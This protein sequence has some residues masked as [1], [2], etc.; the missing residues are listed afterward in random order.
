MQLNPQHFTLSKLFVGRLFRIPE[1]QRPYAW[2]KPQ[3]IDLF[4]DLLEVERSDQDHFMATLVTLKTGSRRIGPDEFTVVDVVDGQQRLTTLIML[5]KAIE[6]ALEDS[7]PKH[8]K[9]KRDIAEL[10]VKEDALCPVLLQTNHDTTTV[11]IEFLRSGDVPDRKGTTQAEQNLLD[12]ARECAV[13]VSEWAASK[14]LVELVALLR[15]RLSFIYHELDDEGT[16]Y[17]VFEVLNSRGLDVKWIDKLKS[18]LMASLFALADSTGKKEVIHEMHTAWQAIYQKL[19]LLLNIGDQALCFAATLSLQQRPNR[20]LTQKDAAAVLAESAGSQLRSIMNVVAWLKRVVDVVHEVDADPR[21]KAVVSINHARFLRVAIMLRD[22]PNDTKERLLNLWENVTFRVYG[23]AELDSRSKVG[24]YVR[25]G[26]SV[27]ANKLGA[28]E[29]EKGLREL[30][31]DYSIDKILKTISWSDC[32]P[33]W[34]ESLRYLLYRYEEHLAAVAGGDINKQVWKRIWDAEPSRSVEH[35]QPQSSGFRYVHHL[36]NL[37]MLPPGV[38]SSLQD[39][40][41][42]KKAERYTDEGIRG[43]R[44]VAKIIRRDGW[45]ET[46]V[47]K[48]AERIEK[49]VRAEW[50]D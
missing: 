10:L 35:I 48:R 49:F 2:G 32:Y 20:V 23:L 21:L 33:G 11:M 26:H 16:V 45:S 34:A 15:N 8:V 9:V 24:D 13:F 22:F 43:T 14:D 39:L 28:D 6:V 1:Y 36:G 38:N 41:P 7:D 50:A 40:P 25:L 31:K 18:Q 5:L 19:G 30:G 47:K 3:R 17:R 27:F 12:A 37:T 44:E 29:I 4:N 42:A 46:E